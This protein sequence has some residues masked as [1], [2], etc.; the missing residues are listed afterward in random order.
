MTH[1][2]LRL[3][4]YVCHRLRLG[5]DNFSVKKHV[6]YLFTFGLKIYTIILFSSLKFILS[7]YKNDYI[8]SKTSIVA[9]NTDEALDILKFDFFVNFLMISLIYL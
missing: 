1:S 5:K 4:G 9:R 2:S 6:L 7:K 3:R 8:S